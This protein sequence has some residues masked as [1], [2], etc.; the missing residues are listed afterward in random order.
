MS[1]AQGTGPVEIQVPKEQGEKLGIR[2]TPDNR[3]AA[4]RC[5]DGGQWCVRCFRSCTS[6]L[7][8]RQMVERLVNDVA[9]GVN[10][11]LLAHTHC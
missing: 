5:G 11:A 6:L 4:V 3:V 2:L 1:E 10:G 8:V 9:F 7:A